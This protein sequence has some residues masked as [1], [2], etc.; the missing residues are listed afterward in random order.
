[1]R[2]FSSF[3]EVFLVII[4]MYCIYRKL[5]YFKRILE[6][7]N[8]S[9]S[10]P[11]FLLGCIAYLKSTVQIIK[12]IY[13]LYS[14][15]WLYWVGRFF[16]SATASICPLTIHTSLLIIVNTMGLKKEIY[17]IKGVVRL[18]NHLY[19]NILICENFWYSTVIFEI[20]FI[21]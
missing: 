14:R 2:D 16:Q 11:L 20:K 19:Y 21:I 12:P 15:I 13:N 8:I 17:S 18:F 5:L 4:R 7:S 1:M 9:I 10:Y 3:S 6:T